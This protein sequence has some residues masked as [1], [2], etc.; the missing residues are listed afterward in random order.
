MV[1]LNKED[2]ALIKKARKLLNETPEEWFSLLTEEEFDRY[3]II[4]DLKYL[5]EIK[6]FGELIEKLK[7]QSNEENT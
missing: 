6:E 5:D 4:E 1:N 2:R 7:N 3:I